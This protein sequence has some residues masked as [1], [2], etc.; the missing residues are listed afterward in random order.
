MRVLLVDDN[1][2]QLSMLRVLIQALGHDVRTEIS[3]QSAADAARRFKP[4]IAFVDLGLPA[5]SGHDLGRLLKAE[6]P[7]IRLYAITGLGGPEEREKSLQAGFHDHLVK[8][9]D[10]SVVE[11]LLR[12]RAV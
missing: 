6:A 3:A 5:M 4:D 9:V 12:P 8:P 10:F 2:D 1:P 7:S 11:S